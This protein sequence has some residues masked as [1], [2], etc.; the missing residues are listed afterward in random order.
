MVIARQFEPH[1]GFDFG[2]VGGDDM[3]GRMHVPGEEGPPCL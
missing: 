1:M 2:Q 3:T